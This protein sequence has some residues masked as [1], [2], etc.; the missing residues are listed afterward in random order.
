MDY[1]EAHL[2]ALMTALASGVLSVS[3]GGTTTIYR[4]VKELK[5][6]ISTV[7][8][9]RAAKDGKATLS[10]VRVYATKDL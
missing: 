3:Y 10:Q 5:Q 9:A 8:R 1:T 6:A 4:S 7:E 2:D